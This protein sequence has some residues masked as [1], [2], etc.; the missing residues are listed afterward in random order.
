MLSK[1]SIS[2]AVNYIYY[3]MCNVLLISLFKY[4]TGQGFLPEDDPA[5]DFTWALQDLSPDHEKHG[6]EMVLVP[7]STLFCLHYVVS[8]VKLNNYSLIFNS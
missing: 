3:R 4:M 5:L 6:M 2:Y 1:I 7:Y 8:I